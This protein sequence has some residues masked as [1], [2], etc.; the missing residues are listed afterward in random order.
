MRKFKLTKSKID[1]LPFVG[2]D[3]VNSLGKRVRQ[4]DYFDVELPGF[5]VRVNATKKTFFV[6]RRVNGKLS[7][8]TV[9][10]HGEITADIARKEAKDILHALSKGR[11]VNKEKV[12]ARSAKITL[13]EV[14]ERYI[15]ENILRPN[16]ILDYRKVLRLYAADWLNKPMIDISSAMIEIRH[17]RIK[18][19]IGPTPAN[20]LARYLRLLF[21][22][23][24]KTPSIALDMVHHPVVVQWGEEKRR[25]TYL[26]ASQLPVW[27]QAVKK[28]PSPKMQDYFMLLL[29]TGL[30]KNEALSL[31][32]DDINMGEGSFVIPGEVA[33]NN[34]DHNLPITT[35]LFEIFQRRAEVRENEF[36]FP[37]VGK[38][39]HLAEPRKQI[40]RLLHETQKIINGVETEEKWK[41]FQKISPAS[42][43]KP[44]IKFCN[45]DLRRTFSSIAEAMVSYSQ[46]KRLLN[47]ST[48]SDVTAGYIILDVERLRMPAQKIA[49]EID[50]FIAKTDV[51]ILPL[52]KTVGA[53]KRQH[54]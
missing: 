7:R 32:W 10:S 36:V 26:N 52:Q 28:L 27:V 49:D 1:A 34:N 4:V 39:R 15:E 8:V 48:K 6:M 44:G 41:A 53:G 11:D 43:V 9:G 16:T 51:R 19:K 29:Y 45:H 24:I 17:K 38:T 30:R 35:Q 40:V 37:G 5:G 23:A 2:P 31:K 33:K 54:D 47:H 21:N 22:Y 18:N 12:K 50:S 20:K 13:S 25:K 14:L 46:M 3:T 42:K